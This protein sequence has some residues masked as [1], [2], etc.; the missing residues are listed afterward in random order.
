MI[1]TESLK[2]LMIFCLFLSAF[3]KTSWTT[4]VA[5]FLLFACPS[6]KSTKLWQTLYSSC[7]KKQTKINIRCSLWTKDK[8]LHLKDLFLQESIITSSNSAS[9]PTSIADVDYNKSGWCKLVPCGSRLANG[10]YSGISVPPN[11]DLHK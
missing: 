5:N 4:F 9:N 2:S 3:L 8:Q 1:Y 10:W 7:K 6:T 11:A